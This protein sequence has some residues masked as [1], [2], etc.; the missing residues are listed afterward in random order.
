MNPSR[1]H[2]APVCVPLRCRILPPSA[3]P[4][5]ADGLNSVG[6]GDMAV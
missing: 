4:V 6:N 5:V 1:S 3:V 2:S